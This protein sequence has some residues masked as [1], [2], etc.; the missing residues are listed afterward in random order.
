[1]KD[2]LSL[3]ILEKLIMIF[4]ANEWENTA[5]EEIII[6]LLVGKI[7]VS[8]INLK[9]RIDI[10]NN[11]KYNETYEENYSKIL[12]IFNLGHKYLEDY[13]KMDSESIYHDMQDNYYIFYSHKAILYILN[14]RYED[15]ILKNQLYL[16]DLLLRAFHPE[17]GALNKA[18]YKILYKCIFFG[19]KKNYKEVL[20]NK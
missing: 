3:E 14:V 4:M 1:M 18:M 2:S 16:S 5:Y 20:F 19:R 10:F 13:V 15:W 7:I 6:G 8:N 12:N 11:S 9:K 17:G